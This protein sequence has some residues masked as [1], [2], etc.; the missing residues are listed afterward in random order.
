MS[1]KALYARLVSG[2]NVRSLIAKRFTPH[3][4]KR[5]RGLPRITYTRV[6]EDTIRSMSGRSGLFKASYR[7]DCWAATHEEA[8]DLADKVAIRLDVAKSVLFEGPWGGVTVQA[9]FVEDA[10]DDWETPMFAD[11]LGTER[12]SRD[13][14]LWYEKA[15]S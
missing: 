15:V 4:S 13:V 2:G 3:K 11:D 7:L 12:V 10:S 1:G 9:C 8:E 14:T 5:P 6:S